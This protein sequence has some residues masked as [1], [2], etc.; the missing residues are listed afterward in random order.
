M[1]YETFLG[2]N[3]EE[4]L[5][6]GDAISKGEIERLSFFALRDYLTGRCI[7]FPVLFILP[8]I[9]ASG[10]RGWPLGM[11]VAI[12]LPTL[13]LSW[14]W[15]PTSAAP[16]TLTEPVVNA[17]VNMVVLGTMAYMMTMASKGRQV[18]QGVRT[19][20]GVLPICMWCKKIRDDQGIWQVLE[21]YIM[22]H[23]E[24]NFTHGICPSCMQ[25]RYR[26]YIEPRC[27][28]QNPD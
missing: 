4:K 18:L 22:E 14:E 5:G 6:S 8:V 7:H 23:S 16:W 12:L 15:H 2:R 13:R 1:N 11:A 27:T 20:Q 26:Q 24:A 21:V 9:F 17:I 28:R 19:L 3:Q 25:E 10:Y